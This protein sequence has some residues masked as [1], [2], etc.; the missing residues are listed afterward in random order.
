MY[1]NN[2]K[3]FT[4]DN[5]KISYYNIIN[6]DGNYDLY[7]YYL[8]FNDCLKINYFFFN[9]VI[10]TYY[11]ENLKKFLQSNIMKNIYEKYKEKFNLNKQQVYFEYLFNNDDAFNELKE[12]MYFLPFS[13][14]NNINGTAAI[15]SR[16]IMKIFIFTYPILE[17]SSIETELDKIVDYLLN[18]GYFNL[19]SFHESGG[20]YLFSYYCYLSDIKNNSIFTPKD[21][22]MYNELK[23]TFDIKL[24]DKYDRG[25]LLE[26]ILFGERIEILYLFGAIYL[27][28]DFY[29]ENNLETI[30]INFKKFNTPNLNI[31]EIEIKE[32]DL[33]N[34][35]FSKFNI[36]ITC[37]FNE[38]KQKENLNIKERNISRSHCEK[39]INVSHFNDTRHTKRGEGILP[40]IPPPNE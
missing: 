26:C 8:Y 16:D 4:Y 19:C 32:S 23:K 35:I 27:L 12:N 14:K 6:R 11:F 20:H 2:D 29:K 9:D 5:N 15:T 22:K 33:L 25:D 30:K 28:T 17:F 39:Y 1:V 38:L 3:K 37:F 18:Y 10:K 24:L 21:N 34:E 13:S 40:I 31:D 36:S 7:Y